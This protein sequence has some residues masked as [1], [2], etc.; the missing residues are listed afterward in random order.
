MLAITQTLT[1]VREK[2]KG[3]KQVPF[4]FM[5]VLNNEE[6][7]DEEQRIESCNDYHVCRKENKIIDNS[8]KQKNSKKMKPTLAF[9]L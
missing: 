2:A 5:H 8:Q 1:Q 3:K 4:V 6:Q 9:L 7:G